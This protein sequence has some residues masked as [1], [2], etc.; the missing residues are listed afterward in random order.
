MGDTLISS[1]EGVKHSFNG[2]IILSIAGATVLCALSHQALLR[3]Q[4][5]DAPRTSWDALAAWVVWPALLL[6]V[7]LIVWGSLDTKR[8]SSVG[9]TA[10]QAFVVGV[11][12][13]LIS[14]LLDAA[15]AAIMIREAPLVERLGGIMLAASI[16]AGAFALACAICLVGIRA[17]R[18]S[19]TSQG[20]ER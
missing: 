6:A 2:R 3:T 4:F 19:G 8:R 11:V 14:T 18:R 10:L 7:G 12:G 9:A 5:P 13:Y 1:E 16:G 15:G 20:M 17:L